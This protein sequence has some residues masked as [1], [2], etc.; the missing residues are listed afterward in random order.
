M[1]VFI[2]RSLVLLSTI[3]L[4]SFNLHE[5]VQADKNYKYKAQLGCTEMQGDFMVKKSFDSI[6]AFPLCAR[7]SNQNVLPITGFDITYAERGLYEDSTGLPII[8]TDYTHA[9][10]DGNSLPKK[11]I[12]IFKERSYKGDTI[13]FENI[14][15]SGNSEQ[16]ANGCKP[17]RIIIR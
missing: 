7:D 12:D 1:Q 13:F 16:K 15:V 14:K 9:K 11:W 4:S 6:V 2:H 5:N 8:F 10:I 3:T 17:L